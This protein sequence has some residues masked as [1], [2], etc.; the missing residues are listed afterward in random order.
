ME[1]F[2]RLNYGSMVAGYASDSDAIGWIVHHIQPR[3]MSPLFGGGGRIRTDEKGIALFTE[4]QSAA[5]PL[6]YTT[7][8]TDVLWTYRSDLNRGCW[9]CSPVP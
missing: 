9:S 5:L 1:A 2:Y 8:R 6:G 4:L 7:I 3:V